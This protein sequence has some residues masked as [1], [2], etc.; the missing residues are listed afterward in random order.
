[1]M[2]YWM[3]RNVWF[4]VRRRSLGLIGLAVL[5]AAMSMVCTGAE[6]SDDKVY[7]IKAA[8]MYNFLKSVTWPDAKFAGAEAPI[9][10]TI[11]GKD[12]F[13]SLLDKTL[14]GKTIGGHPIKITRVA[15]L[16]AQVTDAHLLFVCESAK[17]DAASVLAAVANSNVLTVG[18][19]AG[20]AKDGG[21]LNFAEVDGKL[22]FEYSEQAA[23]GG[24]LSVSSKLAAAAILVG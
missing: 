14:E 4:T 13:G 12:P 10:I 1:M 21:I 15:E 16:G 22:R 20:F 5:I 2:T 24:G 3:Q 8:Y 19:F 9:Q 11:L 17:S 7:K 18:D 6:A 23:T